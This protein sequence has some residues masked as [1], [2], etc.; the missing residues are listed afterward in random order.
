MERREFLTSSLATSAMAL[1]K[2]SSAQSSLSAASGAAR[3]Y[4]EIRKYHLQTGPQIKLTESYVAD[5]LIPALNRL[6]I[7]PVGAFHL[8]FGPETPTLY[9]LLP[10][11][12][13]EV[14]ATAELHL[15]KDEQFMKAAEP[16]WNAPATAPAFQRIES[17]LLIAF[18]GWPRLTPPASTANNGKR[19]F[20]LRTYESASSQDHVRKVEMF[21]HGEFEIFQNAG[22]GQVFYGDTLIG[23]R[24]PNLTYMLSFADMND[25]NAKWDIFHNDPAWKK[26]KAAPRYSYGEIVSN[27][28]NLI[29]SPA[30]YSQI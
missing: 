27:I 16:F 3:E 26:L 30:T 24:M 4:Y 29:L 10:S 22:F 20:Q 12:K 21:Q 2:Q 17:S 15:A 11:A 19:I 1:A 5:A 14:L 9:L 18:E 7:A 8:D 23:P 25:M 28:S 6:G 13:L